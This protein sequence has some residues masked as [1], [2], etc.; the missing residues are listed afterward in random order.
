M[1]L[2]D[3]TLDG[4]ATIFVWRAPGKRDAVLGLVFNLGSSRWARRV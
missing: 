4:A 2:N 1:D 3:V